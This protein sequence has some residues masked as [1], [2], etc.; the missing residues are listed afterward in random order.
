M[1]S[2]AYP[3]RDVFF[4]HRFVRLLQKSCAAQDIGCNACLLLCYIAHTE[5]AARYSGPVRFWNEQLMNV[6]GFKSPK[7]LNDAR[8]KAE[9]AGWLVYIRTGNREVGRYWVTIPEHFEGLSDGVIEENHSA[10]HSEY[11]TNSGMNKERIPERISDG[12]RNEFETESGKPS[13]PI[14]FPN[15]I[16][17]TQTHIEASPPVADAT[18]AIVGQRVTAP[19]SFLMQEF[20]AAFGGQLRASEKRQKAANQRWKDVWWRENWQAALDRGSQSAFLCGDSGG[21]KISFDWFLRPDS[22]SKI[23]EGNYDGSTQRTQQQQT[24]AERREQLNA[25]SFDWI[26]QA[27]AE[28]EIETSVTSSSGYRLEVSSGT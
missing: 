2:D 10:N 20:V 13:N 7:Q 9:Q 11:G 14:P 21:W 15:P 17:K 27:T 8:A 25:S 19:L 18:P 28:A 3:K 22:V 6:M 4:S 24:A 16:P 1:T 23:L 5:D 26:R 12:S